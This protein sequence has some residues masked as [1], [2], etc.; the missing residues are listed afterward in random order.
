MRHSP[1]N[2]RFQCGDKGPLLLTL[3]LADGVL[4]VIPP[5][6]QTPD[7]AARASNTLQWGNCSTLPDAA[8]LCYKLWNGSK[9]CT[10]VRSITSHW[11]RGPPESPTSDQ[12]EVGLV[13]VSM[14]ICTWPPVPPTKAHS[15]VAASAK[16]YFAF[17]MLY[18][19]L[20]DSQQ[21]LRKTQARAHS[22][23][24]CITEA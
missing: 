8:R 3:L 18:N 1:S 24:W 16:L 5:V 21:G 13:K 14:Y 2:R 7:S 22:K 6:T 23:T 17:C 12:Q 20:Q 11:T 19:L 15:N 4:V 10:F 9:K